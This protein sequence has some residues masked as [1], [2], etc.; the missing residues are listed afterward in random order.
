[1]KKII[2]VLLI[3]CMAGLGLT[4]IQ[5][6]VTENVTLD[7][8]GMLVIR[9]AIEDNVT[10]YSYSGASDIGRFVYPND[11]EYTYRQAFLLDGDA[12]QP[13][14]DL[15]YDLTITEVEINYELDVSNSYTFDIRKTSQD[16]KFFTEQFDPDNAEDDW[17]IVKN[18]NDGG[19][20]GVGIDA[21]HS[22]YSSPKSFTANE[23]QTLNLAAYDGFTGFG[24]D[25]VFNDNEAS[26]EE[27]EWERRKAGQQTSTFAEGNQ[28]PSRTVA[29]ADDGATFASIHRA[30]YN[31][32]RN[33]YSPEA[34]S[35]FNTDNGIDYTF[36]EWSDGETDNTRTIDS[37]TS[38]LTARYK[39]S[40]LTST[41]ATNGSVGQRKIVRTENGW[42]HRTYESLGHVWYEAKPPSGDWEFIS[43]YSSLFVDDTGGKA[44]SIAVV[45]DASTPSYPNSVILAWQQGTD[46]NMRIYYY[47]SSL[48]TYGPYYDHTISGAVS[49]SSSNA[50]A[51]VVYS[52]QDQFIV[53]WETSSGIE[54]TL[55]KVDNDIEEIVSGTIPYTDGNSGQVAASS[56]K[57]Y[58]SPYFDVAWVQQGS[59]G[60]SSIKFQQISESSGSVV[61][62]KSTPVTISSSYDYLNTNVSVITTGNGAAFSWM[63]RSTSYW[64]PMN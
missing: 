31:I 43:T 60:A 59:G 7:D 55:L 28:T 5:A 1:M 15:E 6:Q 24:S 52:G 51:N 64:S 10:S 17:A 13:L 44:P 20:I 54:F 30:K 41:I 53:L 56:D 62:S 36:I 18:G 40:Q 42:L 47:S 50:K 25:W 33:D 14:H 8:I 32:T 48:G 11:D 21:S 19:N 22:S 9:K 29:A 23:E 38:S 12:L 46:L 3:V 39:G 49:S 58:Y 57:S 35:N 63:C 37:P 45:S 27:S 4:P 61:Y 2:K 34:G 26:E 16:V